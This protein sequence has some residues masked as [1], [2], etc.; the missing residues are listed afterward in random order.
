MT[1]SWLK[2]H[3]NLCNVGE[4]NNPRKQH[5]HFVSG[6]WLVFLRTGDYLH[7]RQTQGS[8]TFTQHHVYEHVTNLNQIF[9][10]L[11][12]LL[13]SPSDPELI[14]WLFKCCTMFTGKLMTLSISVFVPP[15]KKKVSQ[16]IESEQQKSCGKK[17]KQCPVRCQTSVVICN[18]PWVCH[19]KQATI[20]DYEQTHDPSLM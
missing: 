13:C 18:D 19:H 2:V 4:R 1:N 17:T 14:I 16:N 15:P 3:Y 10:S 20:S 12:A 6:S 7:I 5:Y 11:L 8:I 9:Y